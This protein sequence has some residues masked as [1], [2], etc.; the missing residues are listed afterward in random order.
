MLEIR[1]LKKTFGTQHVL[2]GVNLKINT[3]E[4]TIIIG[5]SGCGKSVLLKHLI[6]LLKPDEGQI[7]LD[8]VNLVDLPKE[9]LK[10]ARMRFGMLFQDAALFDSM[11]AYE[12]IAF[13]LREHRRLSEDEIGGIVRQKLSQVGL[14]GVEKKLPSELSGGMRK[15]V[16]LARA[17]VLNPE[18]VLYD[19]PTTGLD[20]ISS[21]AIDELIVQTQQNIEGTSIIISHD[22]R[23]TLRIANRVAMLHDG[24]IVAVGTPDEMVDSDNPIVRN[25]LDSGLPQRSRA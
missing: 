14:K 16:G 6:G 3:G 2:R 25:F 9:Q 20:P 21:H 13:P 7:L 8:G 23:A 11:N 19:E 4:I 1:N 10:Q 24:A 12:N 18:I 17:L 15:R 5:S 22:I